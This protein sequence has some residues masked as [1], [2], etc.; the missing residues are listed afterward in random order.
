MHLTNPEKLILIMLCEIHEKLDIRSDIN[1]ELLTS[2]IYSD[3][4]WAL[5]WQMKGIVGDSPQPTPPIVNVVTSILGMWSLIEQAY[6]K[7]DQPN[8]DKIESDTAT[9][10]SS[11]KFSGFDGNNESEHLSIAT[12]LVN[13]MGRFSQFRGR[14]LNSHYPSID[15]RCSSF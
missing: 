8:K 1:T 5:S 11:V 2:A 4:T 7:F 13:D 6:E 15:T 10:G 14:D 12:F 3:N 9:F